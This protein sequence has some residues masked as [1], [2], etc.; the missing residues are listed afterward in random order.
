MEL[1]KAT[2]VGIGGHRFG[3]HN[4]RHSFGNRAQADQGKETSEER[5]AGKKKVTHRGIDA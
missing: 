5:A 2:V 1:S 3:L 4:L